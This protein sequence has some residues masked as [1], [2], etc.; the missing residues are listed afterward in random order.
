[1][2]VAP[3]MAVARVFPRAGGDAR[4]SASGSRWCRPRGAPHLPVG[5][6]MHLTVRRFT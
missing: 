3:D 5:V 4:V 6:R 1:M 2:D